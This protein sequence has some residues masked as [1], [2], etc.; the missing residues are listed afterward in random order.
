MRLLLSSQILKGNNNYIL[1]NVYYCKSTN[2]ILNE[3]KK[4][5]ETTVGREEIRGKVTLVI[6][7]S[8]RMHA[9]TQAETKPGKNATPM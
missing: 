6:L 9:Y 3:C 2:V 7:M 4:C 1:P 5:H 8:F